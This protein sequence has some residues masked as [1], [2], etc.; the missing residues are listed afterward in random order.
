[1]AEITGSPGVRQ[2]PPPPTTEGELIDRIN[3]FE[4]RFTVIEAVLKQLDSGVR[5]AQNAHADLDKKVE[6]FAKV[7]DIL[8]ETVETLRG[9]VLMPEDLKDL[10]S[11]DLTP[12]DL[13]AQCSPNRMQQ[14]QDGTMQQHMPLQL[15]SIP[16]RSAK[17]LIHRNIMFMKLKWPAMVSHKILESLW[18]AI[19]SNPQAFPSI[20]MCTAF[21]T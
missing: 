10:K 3:L 12:E 5:T 14:I 4:H 8:S 6:H 11:E 19:C 21:R 7:G 20:T 2:T 17:S 9:T 15:N 13:K 18:H 16:T 1:M